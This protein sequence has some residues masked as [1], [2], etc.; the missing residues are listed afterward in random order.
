MVAPWFCYEPQGVYYGGFF[1]VWE[2]R[3]EKE[4]KLVKKGQLYRFQI[5]LV[6]MADI[7]LIFDISKGGPAKDR[8]INIAERYDIHKENDKIRVV[9]HKANADLITLIEICKQW[10]PSELLIGNQ[11]Y[12]FPDVL[13]ILKC[14]DKNYC[15]GFCRK[16]NGLDFGLKMEIENASK[17]VYDEFSD[18]ESVKHELSQIKGIKKEKDGSYHIDKNELKKNLLVDY[19]LPMQVCEKID[20]EA[21]IKYVDSLPES[22][23]ISEEVVD[24]DEE[25]EGFSEYQIAE[26]REQANVMGPIIARHIAREIDKVFIANLGPE[27]D[28][29]SCERKADCLFEL[30]RYDESVECFDKAL[31]F[32]SKNTAILFG[33]ALALFYNEKFQDAL[34]AIDADLAVEPDNPRVWKLKGEILEGLGK[35]EDS[36][37][38]LTRSREVFIKKMKDDPERDDDLGEI[39]DIDQK[40]KELQEKI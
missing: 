28:A 12:R 13:K 20:Q 21:M 30:G 35:Y 32:D 36:I 14:T 10:K 7:T 25:F 38:I 29:I 19:N 5:E 23:K 22:F 39:E 6:I 2:K 3:Y 15:E 11:D 40:I 18:P 37:K 27:K 16:G 17:G 31:A 26:Y 34:H 9:F 24:V 33:K 8:A 1:N 4:K